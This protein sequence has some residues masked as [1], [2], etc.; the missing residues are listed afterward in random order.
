MVNY[1]LWLAARRLLV[2]S[3]AWKEQ[4]STGQTPTSL[5]RHKNSRN[6]SAS[7]GLE[8]QAETLKTSVTA[9]SNGNVFL[10]L[11]GEATGSPQSL[12]PQ[13]GVLLCSVQKRRDSPFLQPSNQCDALLS[14]LKMASSAF[15]KLCSP[16]S[17]CL[18]ERKTISST[19]HSYH[20][21][22]C[23]FTFIYMILCLLRDFQTSPKLHEWAECMSAYVFHCMPSALH[24]VGA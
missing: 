24:I 16:W 18:Y 20:F 10:M 5:L 13:D 4:M 22:S 14:F 17:K 9:K 8:R 23:N 21:H 2:R 12:E 1:V 3:W 7:W 19:F 15:V 11:W 6:Y